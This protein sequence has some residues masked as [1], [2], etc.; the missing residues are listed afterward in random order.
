[1]AFA[2]PDVLDGDWRGE[3]AWYKNALRDVPVVTLHALSL[4]LPREARIGVSMRW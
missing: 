4:I 3:M 1:M 2:F